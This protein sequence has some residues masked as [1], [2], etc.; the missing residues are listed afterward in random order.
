VVR[1]CAPERKLWNDQPFLEQPE[2]EAAVMG[3]AQAIV[4]DVQPAVT[5]DAVSSARALAAAAAAPVDPNVQSEFVDALMGVAENI[6][7]DVYPVVTLAAVSSAPNEQSARKRRLDLSDMAPFYCAV[8]YPQSDKDAGGKTPQTTKTLAH[9]A[10]GY[11]V[12]APRDFGHCVNRTFTNFLRKEFPEA[13]AL[14]AFMCNT[15]SVA[16]KRIFSLVFEKLEKLA[17]A[18]PPNLPKRSEL[19]PNSVIGIH[20]EKSVIGGE[21]VCYNVAI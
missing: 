10:D 19:D 1:G 15:I 9:M 6:V 2:F 20:A 21:C 11:D 5:P 12:D 7:E 18:S 17:R 8:L 13:T 4:E 16:S 3:M 14:K